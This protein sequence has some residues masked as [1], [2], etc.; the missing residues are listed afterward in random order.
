MT[1][2]I[3]SNLDG[4][5]QMLQTI[6]SY[7]SES[8]HQ[9]DGVPGRP[10]VT[11]ATA[12]GDNGEAISVVEVFRKNLE[13][14]KGHCVVV[15]NELE[16]LRAITI[17]VTDLQS[18]KLRGRRIALSDAPALQR[19]V[20]LIAVEVDETTTSPSPEDLFRFDVGITTAQ[21][22]I[23]ETGTLMLD[24]AREKN[25][26]VS[27]V[28]PVHIAI[29][30]ACSIYPTLGEALSALHS[31]SAAVTPIVTFI[32]GPSRTADIE[33]TLTIG[34]HGPQELY[35]IVNEGEP[36]AVH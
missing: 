16:V 12:S 20:N 32:T 14:V 35:V 30:D 23:A 3:T 22:A 2:V 36:L 5:S 21:G 29:V 8:V 26:L 9:D 11:R 25:R 28:P 34:V 7:L 24:S 6:R 13:A 15:R 31:P 10:P 1:T 19:L 17:I 33:L 4:R 18:T 27:L